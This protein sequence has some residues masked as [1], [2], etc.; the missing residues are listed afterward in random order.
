MAISRL[1]KYA[2]G[3]DT[4]DESDKVDENK[5]KSEDDPTS[6][7]DLSLRRFAYYSEVKN[8]IE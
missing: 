7:S 3:E 5:N 6:D 4:I 1:L 8:A 2:Q